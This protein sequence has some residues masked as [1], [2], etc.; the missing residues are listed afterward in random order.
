LTYEESRN[1]PDYGNEYTYQLNPKG[2]AR[3]IASDLLHLGLQLED[4]I[5]GFPGAVRDIIQLK[6]ICSRDTVQ[7][8]SDHHNG[9][10]RHG[11]NDR[12]GDEV[13]L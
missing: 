3:R 7:I 5:I 12:Y 9:S 1:R 10:K 8:F 2:A 13:K 4:L 11:D 6:G